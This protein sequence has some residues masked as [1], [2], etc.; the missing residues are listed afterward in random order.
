MSIGQIGA[1]GRLG[2]TQGKG[3]R[4]YDPVV[5]LGSALLADFSADH[6]GT[7]TLSG[8]A[9]T[10]WSDRYRGL[11]T[12]Q[13]V[14]AYRPVYSPTR[15]GGSPAVVF[16]GVDDF[17]A[18]AS[19]PFPA[20]SGASRLYAVISQDAPATDAT[21]RHAMSWGG[22][23]G[24]TSRR[25]GRVPIGSAQPVNRA[26][27]RVGSGPSSTRI[28]GTTIDLSTRHAMRFR[29]TATSQYMKV[30]GAAEINGAV[31]P[32]T[33][34]TSA[35]IGA[36]GSGPSGYWSGAVRRLIITDDTLTDQQDAALWSYL[37]SLRNITP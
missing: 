14:S 19:Q 10:G 15:F 34:S 18:L 3:V 23:T 9:V 36:S 6:V 4:G 26:A 32:N 21:E 11:T 30:D 25:Y 5:A 1:V 17:L 37:M 27:S 13:G 31:V 7:L 20:G 28:N 24:N 33:S 29:T 16:D 12:S 2:L 8:S 22:G 35:L